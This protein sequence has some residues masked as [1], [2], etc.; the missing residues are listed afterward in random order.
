MDAAVLLFWVATAN[1][2]PSGDQAIIPFENPALIAGL[3]GSFSYCMRPD[4]S[5]NDSLVLDGPAVAGSKYAI[6][7]RA[8]FHAGSLTAPRAAM[9]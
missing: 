3:G 9:G 6:T 1:R 5:T 2:L 4:E 8:G 7:S